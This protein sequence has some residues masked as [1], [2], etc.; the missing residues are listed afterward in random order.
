VAFLSLHGLSDFFECVIDDNPHKDGMMLPSSFL[1][2]KSSSA[3]LTDEIHVCMLSLNPESED[4]VIQKNAKFTAAG[5]NF[6]S[7]FPSSARYFAR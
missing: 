2:I 7:I 6:L 4:K 3:L 5:G 1:P